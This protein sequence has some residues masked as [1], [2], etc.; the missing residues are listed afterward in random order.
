MVPSTIVRS[1]G[2]SAMLAATT[3]MALGFL[4]G[5]VPAGAR[6][7]MNCSA[8]RSRP[9]LPREASGTFFTQR[10]DAMFAF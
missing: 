1:F 7:T 8:I 6:F 3:T 5:E 2:F 9:K 4:R 10:A